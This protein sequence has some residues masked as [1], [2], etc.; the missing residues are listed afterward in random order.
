MMTAEEAEYYQ[1]IIIFR[2]QLGIQLT[3]HR[4]MKWVWQRGPRR[5]RRIKKCMGGPGNGAGRRRMG[6]NPCERIA[7][8]GRQCKQ[9]TP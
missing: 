2:R 7:R 4:P 1:P 8:G 5:I 9:A 6:P 3:P